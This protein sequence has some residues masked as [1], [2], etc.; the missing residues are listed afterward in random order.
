L[1]APL[2][3][4]NSW[5]LDI[6]KHLSAP[7]QECASADFCFWSWSLVFP[8]AQKSMRSSPNFTSHQFYLYSGR[9]KRFN[10]SSVKEHLKT[11]LET[12]YLRGTCTYLRRYRNVIRRRQFTRKMSRRHLH[13]PLRHST[14]R[15]RIPNYFWLLDIRTKSGSSRSHRNRRETVEVTS[16]PLLRA[17]YSR[18]KLMR[19]R[20]AQ[21]PHS[22]V[23]S[24]HYIFFNKESMR[25]ASQDDIF[26]PAWVWRVKNKVFSSPLKNGFADVKFWET[27]MEGKPSVGVSAQKLQARCHLSEEASASFGAW[28]RA[29]GHVR[30][31]HALQ[32]W[33]FHRKN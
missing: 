32:M 28:I 9:R 18:K 6:Q 26:T 10:R 23:W 24:R 15:K 20:Y 2:G 11:T 19:I 14:A 33:P 1:V 31:R 3:R 8:L 7:L 30:A 21:T 25:W 22:R 13:L 29:R 16:R 27:A 12:K 5:K 17:I 4:W